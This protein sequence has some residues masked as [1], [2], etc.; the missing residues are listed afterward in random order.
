M[1]RSRWFAAVLGVIAPLLLPAFAGAATITVTTTAD[2]FGTNNGDCSLREAVQAASTNMPFGGCA[3]GG[4]GFTTDTVELGSNPSNFKYTLTGAPNE[5]S[6]ATGDL[7]IT[8][9]GPV[10]I[11]GSVDADDVPHVE[12]NGGTTDR[13]F[14]LRPSDGVVSVKIQNLNLTDGVVGGSGGGGAIRAADPNGTLIV[15]RSRIFL[16]VAGGNGGAIEFDDAVLGY[17]LLIS[18]TNFAANRANGEGGGLYLDAPQDNN[19]V[20][21]NS[22]F[23]TNHA[24]EMGGAAYIESAGSTGAEPVLQFVNSTL[25]D[26]DANLGGGAVAFD[27][28][29]GGTVFFSFAT[30][31]NN[32][33]P[34]PG[35]GGGIFT[36]SPDQFVFFQGGNIISRNKAG[37]DP[38]DFYNNC[39]GPGNFD[40]QT[41]SYNIDSGN[42]CFGPTP[43]PNDLLN[44][45]P[46]LAVAVGGT[47]FGDPGAKLTT[48]TYGLY[49]ESPALNRIP[50]ASCAGAMGVDQRYITRPQP[51]AGNCDAGA[52]EGSIGPAPDVDMDG[53]RDPADNCRLQENPTQAN[54]DADVRGDVCDTDDDNDTVADL[55]DTCPT[56]AGLVADHGCPAAV[57]TPPTTT[58]PTPP[59]T[60]KCKQ[61]KKKKHS[62][63]AAKKKGCKKKK[64]K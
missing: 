46:F 18:Q 42:T 14:D 1:T 54:N 39:A 37:Q 56:A 47:L 43:S 29:L 26:N 49:D 5:D 63:A 2:E 8:G 36:N 57:T 30:I 15:K 28:G 24:D 59:A 17:Q 11:N 50:V 27:F 16:N 12:I 6:N 31:A 51:M 60:A 40:S 58:T 3:T 9:G 7:D 21:E 61:K 41:N 35:A 19:A 53:V 38:A 10:V 62:A 25:A 48:S 44:T 4:G 52:F 20:V 55:D 32:T 34:T 13:M 64:K 33:T 45:N 22:T 23:Y